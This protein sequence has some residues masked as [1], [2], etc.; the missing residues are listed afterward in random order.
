[1]YQ[2]WLTAEMTVVEETLTINSGLLNREVTCTLLLPADYNLAGP[3]N[4]LL[5]NDGQE[6]GN[7]ELKTTL[8]KLYTAHAIK[9]VFVAAIHAGPGRLQEYGIAGKPDYQQRGAKADLYTQFILTEFLPFLQNHIRI[10]SF[11]TVAFAGVSLGGLSAF[12]MVLNNPDVFNKAGVFSGSFWW[13]SKAL[14]DGYSD[15]DRLMHQAVRNHPGKPEVKF[16]LE[17]GTNDETADRNK[18]GII[19][20]IED[21]TDLIAELELKGY[22]RPADI[23]YLEIVGGKHDMPTWAKA[24]PKFLIWAFGS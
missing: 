16:W 9:P 10:K 22:K 17:A 13:R 5:M 8:Q 15:N 11:D 20:A 24:M 4:L 7:L 3:P 14:S 12:D 6:A 23:Q 18:N 21:T 19:D 1:M 2:S